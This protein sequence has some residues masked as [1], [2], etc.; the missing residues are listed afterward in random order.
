M[1]FYHHQISEKI[2]ERVGNPTIRRLVQRWIDLKPTDKYLPQIRDFDAANIGWCWDNV[3]LLRQLLDGDLRYLHYGDAIASA[4]GFNLRGRC[5]SHFRTKIGQYFREKYNLCLTTGQP[6]YTIHRADL[7]PTVMC[8]ERL[9]LPLVDADRQLHVLAF[10]Q[11]LEFKFD[12]LDSILRASMDGI[13]HLQA[14][15]DESGE[16]IDL[17]VTILN[18]AIERM[19]ALPAEKLIDHRL[20]EL[21]AKNLLQSLEPVCRQVLDVGRSASVELT[22]PRPG[23]Y[24]VFEVNAVRT[25]DGATVTLTNISSHKRQEQELREALSA[26]EAEVAERKVLQEGLTRMATTDALTGA[27][28]RRELLERAKREIATARRYGRSLSLLIADIDLFKKVNDTYGHAVGD[29]AIR[30]V[31]DICRQALRESDLVAR[32]GGEEYV[33]LLPETTA[34]RA[35]ATAERLRQTVAAT[36]IAVENATFTISVSIGVTEWC[37]TDHSIEA[38]LARADDALYQAKRTGRNK[39]ELRMSKASLPLLDGK[40]SGG[41]NRPPPDSL[42]T[43]RH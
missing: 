33:A 10:N 11:P 1:Q 39:V 6:L 21:P 36:P 40:V 8:W 15:R 20:S 14:E 4:A 37:P 13:L 7:A 12:L 34:E 22:D 16:I 5:V 26:L 3:M 30:T 9:L 27:L 17:L 32:I 35:L 24:A 31:A 43:V 41:G 2:L 23:R 29:V 25:G 38:T 28:N 19:A 18:P 42:S